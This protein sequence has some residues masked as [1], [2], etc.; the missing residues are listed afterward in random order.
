LLTD[1]RQDLNIYGM[2]SNGLC[3]LFCRFAVNFSYAEAGVNVDSISNTIDVVADV[4]SERVCI[5]LI[6]L[7]I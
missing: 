1:P 2:L 6:L 7:M 5:Y 3:I 4:K